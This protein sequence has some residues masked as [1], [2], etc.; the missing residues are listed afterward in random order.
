MR[1][2]RGKLEVKIAKPIY[3]GEDEI[4]FKDSKSSSS[5]LTKAQMEEVAK[6]FNRYSD[7]EDAFHK[8]LDSHIANSPY[9]E[10]TFIPSLDCTLRKLK[11]KFSK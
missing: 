10:E 3:F 1:K 2:I 8:L 4:K 11:K 7:L 5:G 6:H 9:G